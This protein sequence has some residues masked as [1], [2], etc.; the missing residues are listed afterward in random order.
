MYMARMH[1]TLPEKGITDE[2]LQSNSLHAARYIEFYI[3]PNVM[4]AVD[5]E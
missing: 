5:D 1:Y 3:I 4:L 2:L